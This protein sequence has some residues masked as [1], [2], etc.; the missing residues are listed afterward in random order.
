M[1]KPQQP[2]PREIAKK[3]RIFLRAGYESIFYLINRQANILSLIVTANIALPE[4]DGKVAS[5]RFLKLVTVA[6]SNKSTKEFMARMDNI[7]L[8]EHLMNATGFIR[9]L[10]KLIPS[11]TEEQLDSAIGYL[12]H[13]AIEE[14]VAE[15][16]LMEYE[17]KDPNSNMNAI[18]LQMFSDQ[19]VLEL[20]GINL[21]DPYY[22]ETVE[23]QLRN[24]PPTF[25]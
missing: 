20:Y 11:Q 19:V 22:Q 12:S 2:N 6:K 9:R 1:S 14:S 13:V 23:E 24:D 3:D 15:L 16:S 18:G 5:C 4:L 25:L 8:W 21:Q 7:P 10:C 17:W